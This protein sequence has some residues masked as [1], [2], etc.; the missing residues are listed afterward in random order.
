M[1]VCEE[2]GSL[3]RQGTIKQKP[4]QSLGSCEVDWMCV[5]YV[6]LSYVKV[7]FFKTV[8][9]LGSC[10]VDLDARDVYGSCF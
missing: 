9:S 4:V 10:E 8:Q 7:L 6:D 2:Y 1:N 5:K 3:L